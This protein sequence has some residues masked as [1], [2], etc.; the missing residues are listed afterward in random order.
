[1]ERPAY[2]AGQWYPADERD[3]LA[4]IERHARDTSPVA[5]VWRGLIGPHAGWTYSGDAAGHAYRWLAEAQPDIDLVVL[6]GAH[7]GPQGPNTIFLG[8]GWQ[9]P[10]GTLSCAQSLALR[11]VR[12][13][14][15]AEEP[16]ET[17]RP[18]NAAEVHLPFVRHF[19]PRAELLM[20]GVAAGAV[21]ERIG[22]AVGAACTDR[23]TVFVGSTDLT[24]Y[25]PSYGFVPHGIGE[26]PVDWVRNE[27]DR[28]FVDA[29][30]AFDSGA[31][32]THAQER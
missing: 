21:S 7:R 9:T 12:E 25:G 5:R 3:C 1:M 24:H 17:S 6:F 4:A 22:A 15:L 2:L 26:G 19:F 13:L 20:L 29:V 32:L 14:E 27:N 10:L 28:G 18:D 30:L 31:L 23:A 8:D 11:L 16:V